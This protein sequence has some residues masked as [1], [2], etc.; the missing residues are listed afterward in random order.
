MRAKGDFVELAD[1][2]YHFSNRIAELAFYG[3]FADTGILDNVMQ[4]GCHQTLMIHVH[5]TENIGNSQGVGHIRF[6]TAT[7]LAIMGLLRIVISAADAVYLVGCQ[8]A[9]QAAGKSVDCQRHKPT[10]LSITRRRSEARQ[11]ARLRFQR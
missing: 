3:S 8:I 10:P 5:V 2:V 1:T 6:A 9:R 11:Q 4:H 7:E